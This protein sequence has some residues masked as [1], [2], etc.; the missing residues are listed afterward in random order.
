MAADWLDAASRGQLQK[1]LYFG[2]VTLG[3]VFDRRDRVDGLWHSLE[4]DRKPAAG[5]RT[6][7]QGL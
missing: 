1:T 7:T 4:H 5:W 2:W 6:R 3:T